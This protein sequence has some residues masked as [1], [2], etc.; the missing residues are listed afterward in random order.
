MNWFLPAAHPFETWGDAR[1]R[2]GTVSIVQP[3][4][5][6]LF[7]GISEAELLGAFLADETRPYDR[8]K[9]LHASRAKNDFDSEWETWL[10]SGVVP[11][12]ASAPVTPTLQ[13]DRLRAAASQARPAPTGLELDVVHDYKIL[14]GRYAL[15]SWLQELPDPITKITWD[16]VAQVGPGLAKQLGVD[17]GDLL[18]L[19]VAG[20]SVEVPAWVQP[21]HA[22][23]AVTVSIGYGRKQH[24][25]GVKDAEEPVVV[26][27]DVYPLRSAATP[28]FSTGLEVKKT[29]KKYPL[30]YTQVH[31]S[32]EGR[33]IALMQSVEEF[34]KHPEAAE[35]RPPVKLGS[36]E[37]EGT[38]LPSVQPRDRLLEAAVQVGDG[39]G[40]EP[41][42]RVAARASSPARR[43]TTS[44]WSASTRS[45]AAARCS[46]SAWTATTR[47]RRSHRRW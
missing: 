37:L 13:E 1:S 23:D 6:P 12:T 43:R 9:A 47:G 24:T 22:D 31:S 38:A 46:G 33:P 5:Q 2:D 29:G 41:L 45:A 30:S 19:S 27:R 39:G 25:L 20:R 35:L 34:R 21:G 4:I 44:P 16:N 15:N 14:D 32:T 8:L 18:L 11:G 42:H 28:W 36:K 10:A 3:L 40:H 17:N 7:G 26:G